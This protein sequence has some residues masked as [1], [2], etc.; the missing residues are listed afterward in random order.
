[1]CT[2]QKKLKTLLKRLG[3]LQMYYNPNAR[4]KN[5]SLS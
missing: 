4:D 2:T 1:M 3:S 5:M